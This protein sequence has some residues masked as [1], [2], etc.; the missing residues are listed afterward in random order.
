M[1]KKKSSSFGILSI[2][3]VWFLLSTLVCCRDVFDIHPY[4]VHFEGET[5]VNAHH[6]AKIQ[7]NCQGKDTLRI[8]VTGDTQGWYDEAEA[9]VRSVN[10][11]GNVDFVIHGGDFTNFGA[12][13]EFVK[14]RD[15]FNQLK[16]PW[17]GIIGN[18]DCLGTGIKVYRAMFGETNFS[19]VAGRVKFICLNTNALE[20][21]YSEPIPDFDFLEMQVEADSTLYDRTVF[22]MHAPPFNEQFNNNVV[23]AFNHYVELFPNVLFCTAAHVHRFEFN[24]LFSNGIIYYCSD[25]VNHRNYLVFTITPEG[26]DYEV[27]DY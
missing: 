7:A 3:I 8:V 20:Y 25:S 12:T 16:M 15:I 23:R 18:H 5:N 19:F 9:L 26:Y 27:V 22:C 4:D 21:D 6:I 17:I 1:V 10:K 11:R 13:R 24:D 14:Q 2:L